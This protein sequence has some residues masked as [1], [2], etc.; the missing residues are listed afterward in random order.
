MEFKIVEKQQFTVLGRRRTF[1]E[2]TAYQEIPR[3]WEEHM[4]SPLGRTVCGTYG[5]CLESGGSAFDYLIADNYLPW[6]EV[7][8]GCETLVIPAG[9]WA[10]FPCPGPLPEAL[11]AVNTRIWK[12]WLPGCQAYR[13]AGNYTLEVYLP[14][15]DGEMYS[16]IWIPVCRADESRQQ[17]LG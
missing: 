14:R 16:E 5:I 2:K 8:E 7:P 11:Q 12:E 6:E 17:R 13:L 1:Q 4:K 15:E 3:F 9:T 10:A